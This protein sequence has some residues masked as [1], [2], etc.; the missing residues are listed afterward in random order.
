MRCDDCIHNKH[1]PMVCRGIMDCDPPE[2]YCDLDDEHYYEEPEIDEETG[3]ELV[4][5]HYSEGGYYD[6][7]Y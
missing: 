3:E 2:D 1:I 7:G 4:C 5:E 6:E